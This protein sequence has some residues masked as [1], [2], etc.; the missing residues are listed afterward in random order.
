MPPFLMTKAGD[1]PKADCLFAGI[2]FN[3]KLERKNNGA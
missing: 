1:G 2:G 3:L